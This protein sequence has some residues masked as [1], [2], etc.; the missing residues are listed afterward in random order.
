MVRHQANKILDHMLTLGMEVQLMCPKINICLRILQYPRPSRFL[1]QGE[2]IE[3][4]QRREILF[5]CTTLPCCHSSQVCWEVEGT[6]SFLILCSKTNFSMELPFFNCRCLHWVPQF[7]ELFLLF[8]KS[9]LIQLRYSW[10]YFSRQ[11]VCN[12]ISSCLPHPEWSF[13]DFLMGMM[14]A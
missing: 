13:P 1:W 6:K 2:Y 3:Q 10:I 7:N 12:S 9:Y 11:N 5:Y 8:Y 4:D 14:R